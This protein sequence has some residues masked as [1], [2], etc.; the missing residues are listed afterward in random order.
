MACREALDLATDLQLGALQIA[1]DCMEVVQG[2]QRQNLGV[3]SHI[4]CEIKE[5]ALARGETFFC[6]EKRD[7]NREAHSLARLCF[8][9]AGGAAC[10]ASSAT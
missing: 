1:T 10:V 2:L 3:F 8:D 7:C 5:R 4:L 9:L 6:H